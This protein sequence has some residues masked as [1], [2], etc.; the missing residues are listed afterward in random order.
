VTHRP[1]V[2]YDQL[3]PTYNERFAGPPQQEIMHALQTL[4]ADVE[5]TD[6]RILEIGCGTGRWIV[7]LTEPMRHCYGLDPSAGMLQQAQQRTARVGRNGI[8][9]IT[10]VQ[11]RGEHLPIPDDSFDLLYAV[12]VIH[13]IT[14]QRAFI[15]EAYRVLRPGGRLAI[16]GMDPHERRDLWYVYHY[17]D[18]A[19]ET[20]LNRFPRWSTVVEWMAAAG[21]QSIR[22]QIVEHIVD[23][24]H[25]RAV[26]DDPF[27]KKYATSQLALLSDEA[28]AAGLRRIEAALAE[29]DDDLRFPV[30]IISEMIVGQ[31]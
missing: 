9:T 1:K 31:L 16:I 6:T 25:G 10:W 21:F 11:G 19:Y 29:A 18:G 23:H 14:E 28:Y 5:R 12:N 26:F 17:F 22:R 20:D 13:H 30:E 15:D 4:A 24:K 3:A 27:L 7:E 2:D 8:P